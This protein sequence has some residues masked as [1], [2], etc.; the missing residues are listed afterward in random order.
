VGGHLKVFAPD[1]AKPDKQGTPERTQ[2]AESLD[3]IMR[4]GSL[5]PQASRLGAG[6]ALV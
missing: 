2:M 3:P 5:L 6:P 4:I 1:Y